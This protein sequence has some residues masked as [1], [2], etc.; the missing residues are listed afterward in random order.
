MG[1]MNE[2]D[3]FTFPVPFQLAGKFSHSTVI[4]FIFSLGLWAFLVSITYSSSIDLFQ[5][6]LPSAYQQQVY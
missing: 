6:K 2:V 5:R 1:F 3:I 4:G